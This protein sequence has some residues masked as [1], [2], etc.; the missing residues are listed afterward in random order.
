MS[1]T[2][3]IEWTDV[4]WDPV[5]GCSLMSAG[6]ENCYAMKQA[7]RFSGSGQP[8]AGLTEIGPHGPR[9]TGTIRLVPEALEAPLHWKQPRRVFVNSMSD[10]FHEDVP[11]EF[12]EDVWARMC[13]ADHHIY[14]ILT[15]R[16]QRMFDWITSQD[17]DR[18]GT[19]VA[20]TSPMA[21]H[22]A[23]ARKRA[24]FKMFEH[25]WLGVSVEN[26]ATAD[27][28][29]PILLQTPSA[30]R[31]ISAEPLLRAI[32]LSK[33]P[34]PNQC[35]QHALSGRN[36]WNGRTMTRLDWVVIGGE[37]GPGARPCDL[38]WIRSIKDQCQAAKV[39]VF[40]K[41][42]GKEPRGLCDWKDHES[43]PPQWLDEHG[44]LL[45]VSGAKTGDLCHAMDDAWWP[46]KPTLKDKQ[47]GD[48]AEWPADLRV[49]EYPQ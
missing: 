31:W 47:G 42:L 13:I 40:V 38:A 4:T 1:T 37:S 11:N 6:C 15:K 49:R 18:V 44:T 45:S 25:V 43:D 36:N 9:W 41:Q 16:P 23:L 3:S 2:T 5:R 35:T 39:P 22:R 12:L 48:M 20:H 17:W 28:R 7:H 33:I 26:Q 46:C 14:Q 21:A 19:I 24:G 30:V 34:A 29:I 10:L 27:E 32:D 8:Y